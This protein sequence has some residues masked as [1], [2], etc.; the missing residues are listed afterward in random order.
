MSSEK[1][2]SQIPDTKK[3]GEYLDSV[4]LKELFSGLKNVNIL[5]NVFID[6]FSEKAPLTVYRYMR[7]CWAKEMIDSN[8]IS[9]ADPRVWKDPFEKRFI[10]GNYRNSGFILKQVACFCVTTEHGQNEAAFWSSFDSE[11]Q[12]DLVQVTLDFDVLLN[13]LDN[14]AGQHN[15]AVYVKACDY[16][17]TSEQL[18]SSGRDSFLKDVDSLD[19]LGFINLMSLKR[20]AFASENEL[21]LFVYG[22]DLPFENGYL[23]IPYEGELVKTMKICPE[24]N[25]QAF[26]SEEDIKSCLEKRFKEK[27]I[28]IVKS[29]LYDEVSAFNFKRGK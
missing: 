11:A 5:G 2:E 24:P 4:A 16:S 7:Y 19:E 15:V 17:Y 6:K 28:E 22:D 9:F 3:E 18:K 10:N 26:L 1:N 20:R 13:A 23:R 8:M 14:F 21:R 27:H 25:R 29:R 12:H